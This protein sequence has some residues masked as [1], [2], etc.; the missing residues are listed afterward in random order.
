M[1]LTSQIHSKRKIAQ[2]CSQTPLLPVY[3]ATAKADISLLITINPELQ[4][5]PDLFRDT[6][7]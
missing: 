5:I 4:Q 3:E 2:P 7:P 6:D 1:S